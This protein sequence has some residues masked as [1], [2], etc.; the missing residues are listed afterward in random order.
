MEIITEAM[1]VLVLELEK[2]SG[3]VCEPIPFSVQVGILIEYEGIEWS[4]A[5]IPKAEMSVLSL[6][7]MVI[8]E[9]CDIIGSKSPWSSS[10]K[11]PLLPSSKAPS[12]ASCHR[13]SL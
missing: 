3:Q 2:E 6:K 1:V 13:W 5:Q 9:E 12:L 7:P 10:S 4:P 8:I 11:S